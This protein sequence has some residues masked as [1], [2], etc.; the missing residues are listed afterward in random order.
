MATESDFVVYM[1]GNMAWS[2][3]VQSVYLALQALFSGSNSGKW[4]A[5]GCD[6]ENIACFYH[7]KSFPFNLST[8]S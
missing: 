1:F 4:I 2:W 3:P 5:L 6:D 8:A 7:R